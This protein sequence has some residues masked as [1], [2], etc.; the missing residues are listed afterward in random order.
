MTDVLFL[1][2]VLFVALFLLRS[3]KETRSK[4]T[5][6]GLGT[7]SFLTFLTRQMSGL[8]IFLGF[9]LF[10][11]LSTRANPDEKRT[12]P[13]FTISILFLAS[14]LSMLAW[15]LWL[16]VYAHEF[17]AI[18][19]DSAS[20]LSDF[21]TDP[22]ERK[23]FNESIFSVLKNCFRFNDYRFGGNFSPVLL[24]PTLFL[25]AFGVS[26]FVIKERNHF[27]FLRRKDSLFLYWLL[28]Y[29]P[30]QASHVHG[31][32]YLVQIIPPIAF[33]A[34]V[35]LTSL[36]RWLSPWMIA[37]IVVVNSAPSVWMIASE[38]E[39]LMPSHYS[40]M[41][42]YIQ[43][44]EHTNTQTA[45]A[46]H[47]PTFAYYS[48]MPTVSHVYLAHKGYRLENYS[49]WTNIR[50]VEIPQF[51]RYFAQLSG[52]QRKFMMSNFAW[53]E[54]HCTNVNPEMGLATDDHFALFDCWRSPRT[55][56]PWA[57]TGRI[58][59]KDKTIENGT[60][61]VGGHLILDII[62]GDVFKK[63]PDLKT[64]IET[65]ATFYPGLINLYD[66]MMW[67]TS[68]SIKLNQPFESMAQFHKTKAFKKLK[69]RYAQE[70]KLGGCELNDFLELI[71][72]LSGETSVQSSFQY[73]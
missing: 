28:S 19:R 58:V 70:R 3:M 25:A 21:F 9:G 1:A 38:S 39:V 4:F 6:V 33:F 53:V 57:I 24:F 32:H 10:Y 60:L 51:E 11:F 35:G 12:S 50:F 73:K 27:A 22:L 44:K 72:L 5:L 52:E 16:R 62:E 55:P 8:P 40:K 43:D 42:A 26:A 14:A 34:M 13:L 37:G 61:V 69:Q 71:K 18:W 45:V 59:T 46:S 64:R 68:G 65:H 49:R 66:H 2:L 15:T 30:F 20:S 63:Y 67:N 41:A 7:F 23:Y 47:W 56:A 29:L 17:D 36:K 54:A 48:R 31:F